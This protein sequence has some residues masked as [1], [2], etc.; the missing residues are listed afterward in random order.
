M[1]C[2]LATLLLSGCGSVSS[3]VA[4]ADGTATVTK[5]YTYGMHFQVEGT[6]E[7]DEFK[8]VK[9]AALV[10]RDTGM[11]SEETERLSD[12][13]FSVS[14]KKLTFN[15]SEKI[16]EGLCLDL[17]DKGT[18]VLLL[19]CTLK[20]GTVKTYTLTDGTEEDS[21][22]YYTLTHHRKNRR[23][24]TEFQTANGVE[25]LVF[26]VKSAKL[27]SDVYDVVVDPGH[28]GKDPGTQTAGYKESDIVLE[29]GKALRD[30]LE[31]QGYKVLL[32]RDGSEDPE[33]NMAY[34]AY[35]EGGRVN[36]VGA[37]KAKLCFSIHL[38][39]GAES[40][41][42]TQVYRAKKAGN[43]FAEQIANSLVN[44]TD[45]EYS[46]MAGASTKGVFVRTFT[47]GDIAEAR[48][49][50]KAK[51]Y[52][53]YNVSRS[54]DYYFMIREY[55]CLATDAYVDGRNP[56]YGTNQ[57][58]NSNQ[59]VESCLCELGFLSNAHDR[60]ILLKNQ[61]GIAS[62]LTSALGNYVDKIYETPADTEDMDLLNDIS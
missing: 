1:L 16:N 53:F 46:T 41:S 27:P 30:A 38:N 58:R 61:R 15:S 13:P 48:A 9:S 57:Y 52:T 2:M 49:K 31:R 43:V 10:L 42:G 29:Q 26:H 22:E 51:G 50:A 44:E 32:T 5:Y 55:G 54:T 20:D 37:S 36:Q 7:T 62:A 12:I 45:L 33:V 35:D 14:K 19:E 23:V 24:T 34:T 17:L 8:E 4:E 47:N 40:Q 28:G 3:A 39:D 56:D 11:N 18:S 21:I 60:Q 6:L 59:G 25:A